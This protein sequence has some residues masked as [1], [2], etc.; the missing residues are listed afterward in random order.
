MLFEGQHI[1]KNNFDNTLV[2]S[3]CITHSLHQ[4]KLCT[5]NESSVDPFSFSSEHSDALLQPSLL[6]LHWDVI[7]EPVE[8]MRLLNV[9]QTWKNNYITYHLKDGWKES[10][11]VLE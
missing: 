8:G 6:H 7:L 2:N 4:D 10:K 9:W 11:W 3:V 1:F 5:A